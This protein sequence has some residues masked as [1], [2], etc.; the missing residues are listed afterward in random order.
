MTLETATALSSSEQKTA[1]TGLIEAAADIVTEQ[2]GPGGFVRDLFGRVTPEDLAS[3]DA[4]ALADLAARAR[5]FLSEPR[6]P[7]DPAR[8]RLSEGEIVRDGRARE[9]TIL[10]VINDNRPFLLD[11]TLAELTE[12]GLSPHLVAHPILGVER[13]AAGALIR[14]VG[15][16]TA[17]AHG[18]LARE[19]FIHIHLDRLDAEA[20][21]RLQDALAAVYRDVALASDDHD[22]M[23]ARL[24]D[25]AANLGRAPT[26]MPE[27]ETGEARAF[28][29]WLKDGQFLLLGMQQHGIDGEAASAGRRIEPRRAARSRR[30]APAPGPDA[31]RLHPGDPRLPRGAAA[32]HHHQGQRQV[33][34]P[35]VG[36]PGLCRGQAVL[37]RRQA[38]GRGADRRP[39]HR[40]GLHEPR[41]RGAGPA[42]E[43]R[44]GGRSAPGSTRRAMPAA[45][46]LA[47]LESYPRD[48]LF[49]IDIDRLYRFTLAIANLADRPRIRV[50]SRPDRFGR[51][52]SLLVYV[53]K[54]R[55]DSDGA[56]PDRR[57]PGRGLRRA[58]QRRLSG[59]SRRAPLARTHY[60]IG[61]PDQGAP[62]QRP[63]EPRGRHRARW[64]GPGATRLRDAL[65]ETPWRRPG[66]AA[67]RALRAR[68]SRP[69]IGTTSSRTVAVADIAILESLGEAQPRARAISAA[70][71]SDA[72][73]QVRLK[74]FSRGHRDR[75]VGPGA[76]AGE[77][78]L[79]RH[80]RADLPDRAGGR[81]RGGAGLA[82]RHAARARHR[83][84]IDLPTSGAARSKPRMLAIA[85]GAAESDGYNRL[86]LEAGA[87]L[88]GRGAAAG[89]RPLPAPAAHPLRAGLPRRRR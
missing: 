48:E 89:A 81:G 23:L 16:T 51:F 38:V 20:G 73:A 36:L 35:P 4:G 70:A 1:R 69:P 42:P 82:A 67:R 26:P 54:D 53:P 46:S 65:T 37:R 56:G 74:V 59:L 28:L 5:A 75:P 66:A 11:S 2:G 44:G 63:G 7:G 12:Q 31:G 83:R 14:V 27:G 9:M 24:T 29:E 78:R 84:P 43:G 6:R 85:D 52:V 80:Q 49:Q 40:L 41:P 34:R 72:A 57:L 61:L 76:G 21:E 86:V 32:A 19:S 71:P 77:S 8:L 15:E 64:S 30:H 33:P 17:D 87:R 55:Y 13:D 39:V 18:S 10:E 88:A 22:A 60:I 58:A 25:L 47:V 45:A 50:L 62:E 68:R 3:Y 79:P